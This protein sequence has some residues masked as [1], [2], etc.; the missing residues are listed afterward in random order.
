M[1]LQMSFPNPYDSSNSITDSYWVPAQINLNTVNSTGQITWLCY[2]SATAFGNG[3]PPIATHNYQLTPVQYAS[4]F[5]PSKV[6]PLN[7]NHISQSHQMA[8]NTDDVESGVD[9][10][11]SPIMV[12]FFKNATQVS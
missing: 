10:N 5:S 1:A 8:L 11:G 12:S 3:E 7:V 4:Y 2:V 6:D 9:A